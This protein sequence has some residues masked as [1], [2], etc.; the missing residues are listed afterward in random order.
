M[1]PM[2]L[3]VSLVA[4]LLLV[5]VQEGQ[6]GLGEPGEVP[7]GHDRLVAVGVAPAGVD[8]TVDRGRVEGLHEGARP[9]VDG[10]A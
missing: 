1:A 10:L 4:C 7:L 5:V 8:R 2:R 3:F 6:E 9:V